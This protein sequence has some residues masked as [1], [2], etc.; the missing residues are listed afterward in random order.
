MPTNWAYTRSILLV[1][2][3]MFEADSKTRDIIPL[4]ATHAITGFVYVWDSA[5]ME[6]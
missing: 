3:Q 4:L 1:S 5:M 6:I 2:A